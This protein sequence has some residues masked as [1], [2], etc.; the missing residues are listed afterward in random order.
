[1][2]HLPVQILWFDLEDIAV[3]LVM[4]VLWLLIDSIYL[5]PAVV[6]V[7]FYLRKYKA[8]KPRGYLQHLLFEF[9][10]RDMPDYPPPVVSKFEE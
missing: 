10:L 2:L 4:Y 6:L 8:S 5:L 9:G 7:P 3:F 1:M